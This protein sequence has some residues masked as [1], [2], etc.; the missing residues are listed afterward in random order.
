M[1]LEFIEDFIS[2]KRD[3]LAPEQHQDFDWAELFSRFGEPDSAAG[4]EEIDRFVYALREI[5]T[6]IASGSADRRFIRRAGI[7]ALSVA[8]ILQ[9]GQLEGMSLREIAT[10]TREKHQLLSF[11][12]ADFTRRWRLQNR[13]Q[14]HGW[15]RGRT[16]R[17]GVSR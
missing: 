2:D 7:R 12:A 10:R 17:K 8:Y 14:S 9:A 13:Y 1:K 4:Q 6:W 3:P 16:K 11:H 5:V 15:C